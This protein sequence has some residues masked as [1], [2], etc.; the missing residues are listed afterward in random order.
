MSRLQDDIASHLIRPSF[1]TWTT[2]KVRV[3]KK[4][5]GHQITNQKSVHG[6]DTRQQKQFEQQSCRYPKLDINEP[7]VQCFFHDPK[8]LECSELE[9]NWVYAENGTFYIDSEAEK[10]H[11]GKITC[12]CTNFWRIS[13][14]TTK[15]KKE[16]NL[17]SGS[18]L[19]GD[20]F[21]VD[22]QAPD[23]A[24]YS[25]VHASIVLNQEAL[26]RSKT[27]SL[28]NNAL[29]LNVYIF[30]FDSVSQLNFL[31]KLPKFYKYLTENMDAV[32]LEGYN[33]VGDGTPQALIP[34]LTGKTEVE[35]P[36]TRK[37][38]KDA[39]YIKVYPFVWDE[40]RDL[41]YITLY[42]EGKCVKRFIILM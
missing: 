21:K 6:G 42:G 39:S 30:G 37:R 8:P 7:S 41:D 4:Q 40:Y 38:Y 28:P 22:C 17:K 5:I 19:E 33:I 24:T 32:V 13:D 34:M 23:K 18:K 31:R 2:P 35:L 14:S 12:D 16:H 1:S 10:R 36:L 11:G 3:V 26:D 29:D 25:N 15:S 20:F 9:R 27:K